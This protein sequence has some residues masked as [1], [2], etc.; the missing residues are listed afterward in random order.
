[1]SRIFFFW[2]NADTQSSPAFETAEINSESPST[3]SITL[4]VFSIDSRIISGIFFSLQVIDVITPAYPENNKPDG[5]GNCHKCQQ[6]QCCVKSW[7][8]ISVGKHLNW[9][10]HDIKRVKLHKELRVR[11]KH[12]NLVEY[13]RHPEHNR[14]SN[15]GNF[16]NIPDIRGN[17]CNRDC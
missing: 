9:M 11:R 4:R 12:G 16:S 6:T 15:T 2:F 14:H 5:N 10:Q 7:Q 8:L 17:E 1:A 3:R 13:R